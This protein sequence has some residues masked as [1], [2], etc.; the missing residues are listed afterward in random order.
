MNADSRVEGES[1]LPLQ[2]R[3]ER[4]DRGDDVQSREHGPPRVVLADARVAEQDQQLVTAGFVDVAV[5]PANGPGAATP[6]PFQRV[7]PQRIAELAR[8]PA[9]SRRRRRT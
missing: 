4:L 8:Q 1:V 7:A 3:G 9:W 6:E 5:V 2:E